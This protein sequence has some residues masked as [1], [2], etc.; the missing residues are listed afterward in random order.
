MKEALLCLL[1]VGTVQ[2]QGLD[3]SGV[4]GLAESDD[5]QVWIDEKPQFVF[6]CL[7]QTNHYSIDDCAFVK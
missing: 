3:L 1:L 6:K 5:Y 2:V 4:K 7:K